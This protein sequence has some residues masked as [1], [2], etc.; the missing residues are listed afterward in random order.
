MTP[1]QDATP[2]GSNEAPANEAPANEELI[3]FEDEDGSEGQPLFP[4]MTFFA[5]DTTGAL[6]E[7]EVLAFG[8]GR[9]AVIAWL[10]GHVSNVDVNT[11]TR[12]WVTD[13]NRVVGNAVAAGY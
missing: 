13:G 2:S 11:L 5:E 9:G 4:N 10:D 7:V 8:V 6:Q 1:S 12:G 3:D